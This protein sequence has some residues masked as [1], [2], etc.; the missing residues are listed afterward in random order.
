MK[1]IPANHVVR[2]TRAR[3]SLE[4]L[5]VG[6][7]FGEQFFIRGFEVRIEQRQ[8]LHGPWYYTDDTE[9][10]I[11]VY[12]VLNEIGYIDQELLAMKFGAR[13]SRE[14]R[15]GYGATAHQILRAIGGGSH[16]RKVS[17]AV[18]EGQGSMGNGSAMRVG[19][20]G[21][22]FAEDRPEVI[23]EQARLSAE[24]THMHAE[25]IAGAV[26]TALAAAWAVRHA[27]V[28]ENRWHRE[29]LDFVIDH[30]PDSLTRA[31]LLHCREFQ[32]TCSVVTAAAVLGSGSKVTCPDTVPFA[33]WSAS[34]TM[35]DFRESMWRTVA[36]EG[37]RDTTCAIVGSITVL[38]APDETVP[39]EWLAEREP[40]PV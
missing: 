16:F 26:A 7:A 39:N 9:M 33:L 5:S 11:S 13:Y 10:G 17:A 2:V 28:R 37:D 22:Y 15:R 38:S 25:G 36:G 24:V 4:G 14:S 6:D 29:M 20:I 32:P 27:P 12:E 1:D 40:L 19:P 18:F 31:G 30:T 8:T 23:A 34:H 35:H 3:R 21:A